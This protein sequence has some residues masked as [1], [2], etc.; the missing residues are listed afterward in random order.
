MYL[1]VCD[2]HPRYITTTLHSSCRATEK[3]IK[4][5]RKTITGDYILHALASLG[6]D[7]YLAPLRVYL[8]KYREA[9]KIM[10]SERR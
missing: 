10:Q 6:F 9:E 5:K 2:L 8:A 4:E 3:C 1:C 7:D